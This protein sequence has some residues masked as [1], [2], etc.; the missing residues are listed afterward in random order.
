MQFT[1]LHDSLYH[2]VQ[3]GIVIEKNRVVLCNISALGTLRRFQV[4]SDRASKY[5]SEI[6]QEIDPA[7]TKFLELSS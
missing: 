5:Y 7:I 1:P 6:F 4:H 2:A 3:N